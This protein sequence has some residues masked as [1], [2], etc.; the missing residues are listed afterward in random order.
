MLYSTG[1]WNVRSVNEG[2]LEVIKQE[3]ARVNINILGISK[4]KLLEWVNLTQITIISTTVGKKPLEEMG[5][6]KCS[7]WVQS[8][9]QQNDLCSFPRQIIQYHN[10]P[11]LCPDQ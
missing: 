4:L 6:H 10:N 2:E 3:M 9:K 11:R 5:S 7:P 8:Q 1:A